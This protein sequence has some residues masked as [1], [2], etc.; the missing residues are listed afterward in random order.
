[1]RLYQNTTKGFQGN[2]S[3]RTFFVD[4]LITFPLKTKNKTEAL[5]LS[6]FIQEVSYKAQLF[7]ENKMI[8]LRE[9]YAKLGLSKRL[10]STISS[11]T[12][13]HFKELFLKMIISKQESKIF[14]SDRTIAL[15]QDVLQQCLKAWGNIALEELNWEMET[16]LYQHFNR[17]QY[18][19]TTQNIYKRCL[20]AFF[21]WCKEKRILKEAPFNPKE[22]RITDTKQKWIKPSEFA[23]IQQGTEDSVL[24]ARNRL[25]YYQG[26]RRGEFDSM[27]FLDDRIQVIGKGKKLREIPLF[28]DQCQKDIALCHKYPALEA[29]ITKSF[30]RL[31]DRVGFSHYNFHCLRHSFAH[32]CM[33][34]NV[35][36]FRLQHWLGHSSVTTTEKY[37]RSFGMDYLDYKAREN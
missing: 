11:P 20:K 17:K 4:R 24:Q 7:P 30:K 15:Y 19:A 25:G 3:F 8:Y 1:M 2:Y 31:C 36:I 13:Y 5:Q 10:L 27:V 29:S 12:S 22:E 37:L 16:I 6:H 32:N 23:V 35:S 33:V 34:N 26:L 28:Y 14:R 18:S 21:N 9:I